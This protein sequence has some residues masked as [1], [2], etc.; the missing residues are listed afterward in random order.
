MTAPLVPLAVSFAA[1]VCLGLRVLPPRWILVAGIG[2]ALLVVM[3]LRGRR[4]PAASVAILVL[5]GLA[6][7]GRV[8]LPDPWPALVGVRQGFLQVEGIVSGEPEADARAWC[9]GPEDGPRATTGRAR[10]GDAPRTPRARP[11]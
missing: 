10:A 1:G 6:G 7:W 2:L 9:R 4:G 3:A 5:V 8:G 11:R